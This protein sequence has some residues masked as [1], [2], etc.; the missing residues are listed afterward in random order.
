MAIAAM[1]AS[2]AHATVIFTSN[3]S[4]GTSPS[5]SPNGANYQL[6]YNGGTV[7]GITNT[8]WSGSTVGYNFVYQDAAHAKTVGASN[9]GG[10]S[11]TTLDTAITADPNDTQDNGAFLALDSV[12]ET[13]T[14]D[15]NINTV[16][17]TTYTVS[18]D[19][20]GTQ[21]Q[22]YTGAST[23]ALTLDLGSD[24]TKTTSSVNVASQ[25]FSG[26]Q[27]TSETFVAST[28]GTEILS[29]LASGTPTGD[30]QV[31]AMTLLDNISVSQGTTTVSSTPEPDSLVLLATG[32]VSVGGFLRWR[33]KKSEE[34]S[35]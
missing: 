1:V 15:I 13:A 29:F 19:W 2:T 34:M 17:G 18:F 9:N 28:T 6:N 22:G 16:A 26:W 11:A 32:L 25:G 7:T 5:P 24:P 23:D 10:G 12:Y 4:V 3:L 30:G 14:I 21:Q 33:S 35:L 31:P 8:I 20:G 27:D